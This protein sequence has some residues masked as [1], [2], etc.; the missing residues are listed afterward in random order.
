[1]D[2]PGGLRLPM[3]NSNALSVNPVPRLC[4]EGI[5]SNPPCARQSNYVEV[6]CK[7]RVLVV[8]FCPTL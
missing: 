7:F 5:S 6:S 4:L 2:I 3:V 8:F 1:M